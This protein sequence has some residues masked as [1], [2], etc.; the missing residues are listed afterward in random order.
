MKLVHVLLALALLGF[1]APRAGAIDT[2]PAFTD[3]ALQARYEVL[4]Q[5]LRC[6]MCHN[7]SLADSNA[8]IAADLRAQVRE[9]IAAGKTDDEIKTFMTDRYGDFVLYKP[10]VA[11][12]T[13]LLWASPFVLLFGAL[14]IAFTIIRRRSHQPYDPDEPDTA[15]LE[16][17]HVS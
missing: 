9:L 4:I 11:A 2:A 15:D 17:G 12:R 13:Y 7:N 14:A 8:G 6:P 3:P 16:D 10:P 1:G 5:E